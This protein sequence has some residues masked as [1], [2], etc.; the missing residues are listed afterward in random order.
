MIEAESISKSYGDKTILSEVSLSVKSG[1][2]F[3]LIGPNGSGKSTLLRILDLLEYPDAGRLSIMGEDALDAKARFRIRRR[4]AML[5]Q[6]PI[7]FNMSVFDNIAIGMKYRKAGKAEIR[8]KV[9]S[10]LEKIG[11]G[12]FGGR[13]ARTLSGGEAQRVALARAIVTDPDILFLDEPTANLDPVS[14]EMIEAIIIDLN[15]ETNLTTV[16]ST[17]DMLQGQRLSKNMGVMMRGRLPQ[18]GT[19]HDI[20]YRPTIKDVARFVRVENIF[21]GTVVQTIR[22]EAQVNVNG[23]TFH[24]ITEYPRGT[25]VSVMFRAEDVTL[26][27]GTMEKTSAR[28]QFEGVIETAVPSGPFVEVCV[29]CGIKITAIVTLSAADDLR[30]TPGT[31]VHASVKATTIHVIREP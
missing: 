6:K 18:I 30:L 25:S 10:A 27:H 21:G 23:M 28:N 22:G 19:A 31:M 29:D 16:L 5:H 9:H 7:I 24:A 4:M 1:E 13:S 26:S 2:I 12:G 8:E 3:G 17:H 11:L 15:R 20:F 14:V